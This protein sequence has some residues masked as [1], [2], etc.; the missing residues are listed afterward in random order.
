MAQKQKTAQYQKTFILITL[1]LLLFLII[2]TT[3]AS[4]DRYN[5]QTP[6]I[7]IDT[8]RIKESFTGGFLKWYE[9]Q[10]WEDVDGIS[11]PQFNPAYKFQRKAVD[12]VLFFGI[13]ATIVYIAFHKLL[14]DLNKGAKLGLALFLGIALALSISIM[15][16]NPITELFYPFAVHI[17]YLLVAALFFWFFRSVVFQNQG[18]WVW[19]LLL[20]LLLT[21][22]A[23]GTLGIKVNCP[24]WLCGEYDPATTEGGDGPNVITD[25]DNSGNQNDGNTGTDPDVPQGTPVEKC[26]EQHPGWSCEDR[27][28]SET[29]YCPTSAIDPDESLCNSGKVCMNIVDCD[30]ICGAGDTNGYICQNNIANYNCG[31]INRNYYC[32]VGTC[33]KDCVEKPRETPVVTQPV[34]RECQGAQA[35]LGTLK[36][37]DAAANRGVCNTFISNYNKRTGSCA[38]KGYDNPSMIAVYNMNCASLTGTRL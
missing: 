5:Y 15:L 22:L 18:T 28:S 19:P 35:L 24:E 2:G 25:P 1:V 33:A 17:I 37:G 23:F 10:S 31:S 6:K 34:E 26:E 20:A 13:F 9:V 12:F 32:A 7:S 4:A 38:G 14:Q 11:R 36:L 3:V 30:P 16:E 27:P 21:W 29:T 8:D